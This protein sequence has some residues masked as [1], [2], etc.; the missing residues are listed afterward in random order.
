MNIIEDGH[1]YDVLSLAEQAPSRLSVISMP[2]SENQILYTS[3]F[4]EPNIA[5]PPLSSAST[6]SNVAFPDQ[7]SSALP[8]P[9]IKAAPETPVI[10]EP[11][12]NPLM[13]NVVN[14]SSSP[15]ASAPVSSSSRQLLSLDLSMLEGRKIVEGAN[16]TIIIEELDTPAIRRAKNMK[17]KEERRREMLRRDS[18]MSA[19]AEGSSALVPLSM[20]QSVFAAELPSKPSKS[21]GVDSELSSLSDFESELADEAG[22]RKESKK[23][24]RRRSSAAMPKTPLSKKSQEGS[25]GV[26]LTDK[27]L[28]GGTLGMLLSRF[29]VMSLVANN[30]LHVVWAKAGRFHI[31]PSCI[32][33]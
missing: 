20:G 8:T 11:S 15:P 1:K 2:T 3:P 28:E 9:E 16:G 18:L 4:S 21:A 5:G 33:Y 25:T 7:L 19:V 26:S 10:P 13:E 22:Q 30:F 29:S 32:T 14:T 27:M 6:R 24:K 31:H 17:R 23:G 12:P